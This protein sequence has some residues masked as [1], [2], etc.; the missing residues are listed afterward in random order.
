MAVEA[1]EGATWRQERVP[2]GGRRGCHV[3]HLLAA[4]LGVALVDVRL[5]LL[6]GSGSQVS[7]MSYAYDGVNTLSYGYDGVSTMSYGYDV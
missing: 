7:T 6:H 4:E 5:S 2:R 3:A 1:G